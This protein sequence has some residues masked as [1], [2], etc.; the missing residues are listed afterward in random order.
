MCESDKYDTDIDAA[1]TAFS[2]HRRRTWPFPAPLFSTTTG[3]GEYAAIYDAVRVWPLTPK[4]DPATC[5]QKVCSLLL[6]SYESQT[7][8]GR[9]FNKMPHK[10]FSSQIWVN[11]KTYPERMTLPRNCGYHCLLMA[12]IN[13]LK[14]TKFF[15]L[16]TYVQALPSASP[17]FCHTAHA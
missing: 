14:K 1:P 4:I 2:A 12:I 17:P 13:R 15:G 6:T 16:S 5:S 11:L 3:V 7:A 10:F 9:V 8:V